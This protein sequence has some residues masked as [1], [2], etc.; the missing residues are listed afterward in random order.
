MRVRYKTLRR[1]MRLYH[2][3]S[4]T[5]DF[6]IPMGPAWFSDSQ[7]VAEKFSR[8]HE[9]VGEDA[10]PPRVLAYRLTQSIKLALI[11]DTAD[12]DELVDEPEPGPVEMAEQVCDARFNGWII[13]NNYPTGGDIMICRPGDF[14]EFTGQRTLDGTWCRC[15]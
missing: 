8:W 11:T 13:P 10:G 14:V 5:D 1:G 7:A 2:G 4:A 12:F 15:A 3:T 9:G 6:A